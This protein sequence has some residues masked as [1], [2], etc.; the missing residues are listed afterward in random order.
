MDQQ[1]WWVRWCHLRCTCAQRA[2]ANYDTRRYGAAVFACNPHFHRLNHPNDSPRTCAVLFRLLT[3]GNES[4]FSSIPATFWWCIVT[5]TTGQFAVVVHSPRSTASH[6]VAWR[7]ILTPHTCP[8][9]P[10]ATTAVGYGDAYPMTPLGKAI[11][12]VTFLSGLMLLAIPI[13]VISG[14]FL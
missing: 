12:S 6:P 7:P 10:C 1:R 11:A 3:A 2:N 5:M 8:I 4:Q 13:S 9:V 14:Q